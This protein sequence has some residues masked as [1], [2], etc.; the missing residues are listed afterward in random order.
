MQHVELIVAAEKAI[1]V[2]RGWFGSDR[3]RDPAW[4]LDA[5]E[6]RMI[7]RFLAEFGDT[8]D[9]PSAGRE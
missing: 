3:C 7:E 9:P 6:R 1:S 4:T 2:A 8:L 5:P